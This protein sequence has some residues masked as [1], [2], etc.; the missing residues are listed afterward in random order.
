MTDIYEQSVELELP[1]TARTKQIVGVLLILFGAG[2]ILL[3]SLYSYYFFIPTG[4]FI[5]AGALV[6]RDFNRTVLKYTYSLNHERITFSTTNAIGKT[7][8]KLEI[9]WKDVDEYGD[10]LDLIDYRDFVMCE[11][12]RDC[13]VKTLEFH[14]ENGN[15]HRVLFTP[16]DYMKALLDEN[17][18]YVKGVG[19]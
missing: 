11:N 7:E 2:F 14:L 16:D 6:T 15:L 3:A 10:F 12:P 8:R 9:L 13:G 18:Y 4:V 5:I 17:F 1:K 19:K